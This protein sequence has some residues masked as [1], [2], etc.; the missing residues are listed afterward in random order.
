[1]TFRR[2]DTLKPSFGG[3]LRVCLFPSRLIAVHT[4][5]C[6]IEDLLSYLEQ[7]MLNASNKRCGARSFE[8][9]VGVGVLL[10]RSA[11]M[12]CFAMVAR[13]ISRCLP[14]SFSVLG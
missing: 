6:L 4:R 11:F 1:M 7:R 2:S 5:T 10:A 12:P 14:L 8:G 13:V 9:F 3:W